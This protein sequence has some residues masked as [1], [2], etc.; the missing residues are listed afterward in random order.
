MF[1]KQTLMRWAI[2]LLLL[3][4]LP[5]LVACS[6]SEQLLLAEYNRDGEAEIFLAELGADEAE[7][8]SLAEDVQ[9]TFIF[10]GELAMF[11]PGS[12]RILLWYQAGNDVRIEQMQIGDEAPTELLEANVDDRL[13]GNFE[14]DPFTVYLTE[15]RD[16][17]SYRCYVSQDGAEAVRLARGEL[18]FMNENGVLE[19]DVDPDDGT[20]A[21]LI[22]LDGE[23]ETVLLDEVEDVGY[24]VHFNQAMTQFAYVV[25]DDDEAQLY[26]IEPGAEEGE[27]VGDAFAVID[28]FGYLVDGETVYVIGKLDEDDDEFGLY[29]NGTGEAIMEADDIRLAR[30]WANDDNT[31]FLAESADEALAFIV[32]PNQNNVTE[33]LEESSVSLVGWPT[34]E[35]FL[36]KTGNDNDD[37]ESLYSVSEDGREVVELLTTDEYEILFVYMNA[38]ADQ[39]LVQLRD[40]ENN[41]AVYVTS[42][43]A[44]DGYFLVEGWHS[45]TILNASAE[46]FVFW[47]REAVGDDVALYSIGWLEDADAVE[48]D[49]DVDFGFYNAFFGADGRILYYTAIDNGFGDFEVRLVPVDGSEGPDDLYR[50][51]VLLD[52]RGEDEPNLQLVR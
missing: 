12:D 33:L 30:Q 10:D 27:P 48:L 41:D 11:V 44:A 45:L 8:Q 6:R 28:S 9:R 29:I 18:C 46:Q 52:V 34:E 22:S 23:A 39:L 50:D 38:A 36:L 2:L 19:L 35:W 42:L 47:G 16:F 49:D 21:T 51:T 32:T 20:T 4:S 5:A 1:Q 17:S 40:E 13:F 43:T 37:E 26:V 7:W 24:R 31:L 14:P 15:N 25:A 3:A